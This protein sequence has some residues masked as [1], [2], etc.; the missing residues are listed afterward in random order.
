MKKER[1]IVAALCVSA[2]LLFVLDVGSGE[3]APFLE[4]ES[5]IG[6]PVRRRVTLYAHSRSVLAKSVV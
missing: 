4:L 2:P 5:L 6:C 3:N 1:K